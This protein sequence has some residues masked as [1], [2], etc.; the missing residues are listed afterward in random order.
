MERIDSIPRAIEPPTV[1]PIENNNKRRNKNSKFVFC[2][3]KQLNVECW[4]QK[5]TK[6][7]KEKQKYLVKAAPFLSD[8]G[9]RYL[10]RYLYDD[11]SL[12]F[13]SPVENISKVDVIHVF[14]FIFDDQLVFRYIWFII[15]ALNVILPLFN[16][17]Q[18]LFLHTIPNSTD[19]NLS[20]WY[21]YVKW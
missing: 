11:D 6:K 12:F 9:Y 7:S 1:Q 13:S 17:I 10:N 5:N 2:F 16:G 8:S 19:N 4:S 20:L 15:F 21:S 14:V 18:T 3:S